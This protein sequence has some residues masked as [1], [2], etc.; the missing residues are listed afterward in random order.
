MTV[1]DKLVEQKILLKRAYPRIELF[2][3]GKA[4][5]LPYFNRFMNGWEIDEEEASL[6]IASNIGDAELKEIFEMA[7]I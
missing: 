1:D 7:S 2:E 4:L 3:I 6:E 5:N